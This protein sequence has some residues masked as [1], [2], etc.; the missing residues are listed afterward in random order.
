MSGLAASD[1]ELFQL[2]L[3]PEPPESSEW[4]IIAK[5]RNCDYYEEIDTAESEQDAEFLAREYA[6]AFGPEWHIDLIEPTV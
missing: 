3:I 6:I 1:M 4:R 2:G 5:H